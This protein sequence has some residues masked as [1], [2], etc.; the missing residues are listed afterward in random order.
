MV[1]RLIGDCRGNLS[2]EVAEFVNQVNWGEPVNT[3]KYKEHLIA[4]LSL[5]ALPGIG[6]RGYK[7]LI[8]AFGTPERALAE[9]PMVLSDKSKADGRGEGCEQLAR[10]LRRAPDKAG[11]LKIL[12]DTQRVGCRILC[13]GDSDYPESLVDIHDPPA[14][15]YVKGD[16][17]PLAAENLPSHQPLWVVDT[18]FAPLPL[19]RD[20][21]CPQ[22]ETAL[23]PQSVVS[24]PGA[25]TTRQ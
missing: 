20:P 7:L 4:A 6:D 19:I 23:A 16:F 9:G 11:A 22:R 12:E 15:L 3:T 13:Y 1:G 10:L 24:D 21:L 8:D 17:A 5:R 25:Q 18:P 2:Q 14:Q